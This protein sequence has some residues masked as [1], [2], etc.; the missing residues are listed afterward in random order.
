MLQTTLETVAELISRDYEHDMEFLTFTLTRYDVC[1]ALEQAGK[2]IT[3]DKL[4]QLMRRLD[5]HFAEYEKDEFVCRHFE[6][7]LREAN[8]CKKIPVSVATIE[9]ILEMVERG[10][11][12]ANDPDILKTLRDLLP[13]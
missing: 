8:E 2:R 3:D 13:S 9:T 5:V 12:A 4:S 10:G 1:R 7:M 11:T 6:Q